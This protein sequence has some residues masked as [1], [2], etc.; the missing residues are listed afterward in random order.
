MNKLAT[1]LVSSLTLGTLAA[2]LTLSAG[3]PAPVTAAPA[4]A[5]PAP[6]AGSFKVDAVHSS[7]FFK[8]KHLNVANFYGRFNDIGGTFTLGPAASFNI[9]IKAD[10]VDTNNKKRDSHVM[11][12]DFFSAKEFPTI[13]FAAK[14]LA[15]SGA[16]T[17]RGK[18]DLTFRGVTKPVEVAIHQTGTG[19]GMDGKTPLVGLEATF[20]IK[21]SDFGNKFM[22]DKLSDEVTVTVALE[23]GQTSEA[24]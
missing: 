7:A 2:A 1:V 21:R 16:D 10:S 6:A 12:P 14:D 5:A 18:G 11:S 22:A 19:T 4:P 3:A 17:W 9:T 13:T 15:S 8:I 24:K 23:A 20:T